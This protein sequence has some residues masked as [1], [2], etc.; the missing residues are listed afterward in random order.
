MYGTL[1][2]GRIWYNYFKNIL[3]SKMGYKVSAHDDCVFNMFDSNGIIISTIVIHVDDGFVT[4]SSEKTLDD[5]FDKL[6]AELGELT[7]RRGRV[8]EYL[9]M[10]LNFSQPNVVHI[11]I[12]KMIKQLISDWNVSKMRNSPA[13]SDLFSINESSEALNEENSKQLHRGIAQLLYLGTHVRPDILCATIFLTSRVQELTKQ[14]LSK[15]LD[16]LYYLN[17]TISLGIMLG[18]NS[19]NHIG[20]YAYADASFGVHYDGK[21][22]GGTFISYGRGPILTRSNKLKEVSKSSSESE[23][24]QLSDTTSLAARERDFAIEQQHIDIKE[25]G[26]LLEDNKSAIHMANNG[27]SI[28]NRT[29]H[30]KV[31]YFFVKQYLD[32]GEFRLDHCPTK[33]MIADILTKPLQG[34]SVIT[35]FRRSV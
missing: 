5:F 9:G 25:Q 32:N 16:I 31:R 28:S 20:L 17:Y 8:H 6:T 19:N 35:S 7:I 24:M 14:D 13:K 29:R 22:H 10:L 15:F 12:E 3:V 21:S 30:I 27:K 23:L 4:G 33:D 11:T 26:I 18:G 34:V 1:E 2:A